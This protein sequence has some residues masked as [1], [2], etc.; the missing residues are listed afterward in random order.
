[1]LFL[2]RSGLVEGTVKSREEYKMGR[3]TEQKNEC[4]NALSS[5]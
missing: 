2:L 3:D 4:A 1:V 5:V